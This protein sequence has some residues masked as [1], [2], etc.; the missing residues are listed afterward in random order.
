MPEVTE[1]MQ[2]IWVKKVF[3]LSSRKMGRIIVFWNF[4]RGRNCF[5][6]LVRSIRLW[7]FSIRNFK[8]S[9]GNC[10]HKW[11]QGD[12]QEHNHFQNCHHF[13]T[14]PQVVLLT[15]QMLTWA[16]GPHNK[17]HKT[18]TNIYRST[19]QVSSSSGKDIPRT[20]NLSNIFTGRSRFCK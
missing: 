7:G 17:A 4:W 20:F 5:I 9:L 13:I 15:L 14:T 12:L 3:L 11:T 16:P 19:H 1:I 2:W 8:G 10:I 18:K 6:R